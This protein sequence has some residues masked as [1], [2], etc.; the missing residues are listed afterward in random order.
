M[1]D[2]DL[3]HEPVGLHLFQWGFH[4]FYNFETVYGKFYKEPLR[5]CIMFME[6]WCYAD[7]LCTNKLKATVSTYAVFERTDAHVVK[8]AFTISSVPYSN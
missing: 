4:D 6:I 8:I 5:F 2:C 7:P 3:D 1:L